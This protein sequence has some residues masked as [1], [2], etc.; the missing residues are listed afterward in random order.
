[1]R[2]ETNFDYCLLSFSNG[3]LIPKFCTDI[4]A[5]IGSVIWC[6]AVEAD[7]AGNI[8]LTFSK[9]PWRIPAFSV[10]HLLKPID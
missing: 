9:M 6:E 8:V 4:K 10:K 1:M 7:A 2:V 3:A 5:Y